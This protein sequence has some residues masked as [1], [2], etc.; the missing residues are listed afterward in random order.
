MQNILPPLLTWLGLALASVA[1]SGVISPCSESGIKFGGNGLIPF[2]FES[3]NRSSA[4]PVSSTT[5]ALEEL[6]S[7][8]GR[9]WSGDGSRTGCRTASSPEFSSTGESRAGG[10]RSLSLNSYPV[11][12]RKRIWSGL[13]S[14][15]RTAS[16]RIET[17]LPLDIASAAMFRSEPSVADVSRQ[18]GEV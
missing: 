14:K 4:M 6:I 3:S 16:V 2:G 10:R 12:V 5:N 9:R 7:G 8:H 1:R 13:G 17:D 11:E 15:G 18:E